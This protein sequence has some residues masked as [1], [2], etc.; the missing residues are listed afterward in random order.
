MLRAVLGEDPGVID[1]PGLRRLFPGSLSSA[2]TG[3]VEPQ[4]T[5]VA[6]PLSVGGFGERAL[7]EL[8]GTLGPYRGSGAVAG[9]GSGRPAG[10]SG[11][12]ESERRFVEGARSWCSLHAATSR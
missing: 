9:G 10:R 11:A 4:L 12:T 1:R 2:A 8:R 6:V 5:R 7:D 3:S